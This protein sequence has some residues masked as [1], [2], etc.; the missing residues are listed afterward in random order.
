MIISGNPDVII[1]VLTSVF[2]GSVDFDLMI[3][4]GG[5]LTICPYAGSAFKYL[6]S[7]NQIPAERLPTCQLSADLI[8]AMIDDGFIVNTIFLVRLI[9]QHK[10]AFINKE[11]ENLLQVRFMTWIQRRQNFRSRTVATE[12]YA[13]LLRPFYSNS[14]DL[15]V[16]LNCSLPPGSPPPIAIP[17]W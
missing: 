14:Q 2:I 17:A 3:S 5:R 16:S 6:C 15:P 9:R 1:F 7:C 13:N 12:F 8:C 11:W 10:H 4:L